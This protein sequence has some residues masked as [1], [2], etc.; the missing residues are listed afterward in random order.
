MIHVEPAEISEFPTSHEPR[1]IPESCIM[2]VFGASGD[3][4]RRKLIP[5]LYQLAVNGQLP[6]CFRIVGFARSKKDHEQFRRQLHEAVSELT[7][8][9]PLDAATWE[10][11]AACIDYHQG[12]YAELDSYIAL[13]ERLQSLNETCDVGRNHLFYLAVPPDLYTTVIGN[14]V[15]AGLFHKPTGTP[16][17]RVI[18]EKPFGRDLASARALNEFLANSLHESQIYRIDHYLGKETVQN[19]LVFRF[20]NAIFEPLWNRNHIDHVQITAAESIGVE[21]RGSFYDRTG[22]LRDFVQNHLLE[23]MA[24]C[25]MEQPVSF[26]ADPVRDEKV[27]VLRSLQ[28]LIGEEVC[29]NVVTAQYRGYLDSDGVKAD[30]RTPTYAA[31]KVMIDNWRWQGVPFYL[32]AG[33]SLAERV[34]EV[35]IHFRSVPLCLFGQEEVCQRLAPNVL[36]IRIQPDEGI[37]LKFCCKTPGEN[38]DV[39]SVLMDFGYARAFNRTLPDAYELLLVDAMRGDATLFARRDAVEHAWTFITPII[40]EI[41]GDSSSPVVVYEPG[42][43]GP[44]EADLM[45]GRDGHSWDHLG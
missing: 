37:R 18:I 5:A 16:W 19:I 41:E 17:S 12:D 34:T 2:I 35:S 40:E 21:R 31:L 3:L 6:K 9:K 33:K 10:K 43:Q 39:S 28:P 26:Q 24:L 22:V 8:D 11:F 45:L 32:R 14:L 36:T 25:A 4:T 1:S 38:V 7:A 27:K 29:N 23:I 20:G 13:S 44:V 42:T 30:S 15:E